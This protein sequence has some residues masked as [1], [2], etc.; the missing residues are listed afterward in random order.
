LF[1]FLSL[2][3][4][5]GISLSNSGNGRGIPKEKTGYM[6]RHSKDIVNILPKHTSFKID[7]RSIMKRKVF[8]AGLVGVLLFL[9]LGL[10]GCSIESDDDGDDDEI[11]YLASTYTGNMSLS[12]QSKYAE[13]DFSSSGSFVFI[14]SDAGISVSGTQTRPN[15]A[16]VELYYNGV[17]FGDGSF[18]DSIFSQRQLKLKITSG[19]FTGATG[20]L[21]RK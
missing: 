1:L 9:G 18:V 21:N 16:T 19:D 8:L 17:R 7:R 3:R 12:G 4:L 20:I 5:R 13:I 10:A 14:C 15:A 6:K 2:L 11:G